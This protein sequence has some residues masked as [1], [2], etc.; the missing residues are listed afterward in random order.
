[1]L[2]VTLW[3]VRQIIVPIDDMLVGGFDCQDEARNSC[4]KL[5]SKVSQSDIA[6][7]IIIA[8]STQL[9]QSHLLNYL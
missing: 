2:V 5:L 6:R 1:M 3:I 8:H 7:H 9:S 4:R